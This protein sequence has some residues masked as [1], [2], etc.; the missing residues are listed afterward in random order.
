M[1]EQDPGPRS[2]SVGVGI[3]KRALVKDNRMYEP[4][5]VLDKVVIVLNIYL[6][7]IA[8]RAIAPSVLPLLQQV[9]LEAV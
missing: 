4:V 7:G 5:S 8:R 1:T 3:D 2:L 9:D 6:G